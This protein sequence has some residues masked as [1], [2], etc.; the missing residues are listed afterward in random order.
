MRSRTRILS[1]VAALALAASALIVFV[2]TT[3]AFACSCARISQEKNLRGSDVVFLG[4]K[5]DEV[6]YRYAPA[7]DHRYMDRFSGGFLA[8]FAV[9]RVYKGNV[10]KYQ[11][12][13]TSNAFA[14]GCGYQFDD[15]DSYVIAAGR[16]T[17]AISE[18]ML[19]RVAS[20]D[21]AAA[22][23]SVGTSS[24]GMMLE[25]SVSEVEAILGGGHEPK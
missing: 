3:P 12:V 23:R 8:K 4:H 17:K 20:R 11:W 10:G 16:A 7:S 19:E 15:D 9:D 18:N 22:K 25:P 14:G 24:C 21:R 6:T 2:G 1:L 5:V 13:V